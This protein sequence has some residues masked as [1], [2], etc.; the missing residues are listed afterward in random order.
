MFSMLEPIDSFKVF[1][2]CNNSSSFLILK[3]TGTS[4][5]DFSK[6]PLTPLIMFEIEFMKDLPFLTCKV[7]GIF[8]N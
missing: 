8:L 4:V 1:T 7:T 2:D 3:V 5:K 6:L